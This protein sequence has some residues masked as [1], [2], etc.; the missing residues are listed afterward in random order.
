MGFNKMFYSRWRTNEVVHLKNGLGPV[1]SARR[2]ANEVYSVSLLVEHLHM[3]CDPLIG[4]QPWFDN[5]DTARIQMTSH[6][7]NSAR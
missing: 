5:E 6:R 7:T 3:A 4:P 1:D 2:H